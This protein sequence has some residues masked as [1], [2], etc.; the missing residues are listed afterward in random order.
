M[1]AAYSTAPNYS[2]ESI[3]EC[4]ASAIYNETGMPCNSTY[5]FSFDSYE[6]H[7]DSKLNKSVL[8]LHGFHVMM[9]GDMG[10]VTLVNLNDGK[11]WVFAY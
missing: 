10:T 2:T 7:Y 5:P 1:K 9:E 8:T 11:G 4:Y 3:L 6:L